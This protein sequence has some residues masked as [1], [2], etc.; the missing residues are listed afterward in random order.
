MVG[1]SWFLGVAVLLM[2]HSVKWQR[3]EKIVEP[4][5]CPVVD[6][7]VLTKVVTQ[8]RRLGAVVVVVDVQVVWA[9]QRHQDDQPLLPLHYNVV[10]KCNFELVHTVWAA[11]N[12]HQSHSD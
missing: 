8:C 1:I 12:T 3:I 9:V 6:V 4:A 2:I 11:A 10:M 5:F 7:R